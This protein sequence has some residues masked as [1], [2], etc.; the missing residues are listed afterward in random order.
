MRLIKLHLHPF[1]GTVNKI[2]EFGAG[3][4]V[5]YGPNE[6]GKSTI[7]K[8]LLLAL[9]TST[10]LTKPEYKNWVSNFIPI[11]GDT[12]NIDLIFEV[13]GVDYELK[14]SWGINNISTLS[15]IGKAGIHDAEKVQTELMKLLKLNRAALRDVIFTTQAKIASTIEGI[16]KDKDAEVANSLDQILRSA[17][18]NTGGINPEKVKQQL[19]ADFEKL[20]NNWVLD[21]DMPVVKKDN[22]G[23][24]ENKWSN[25][26][27]EI[28]ELAYTIYDKEKALNERLMYDEIYTS[29]ANA[30]NEMNA[31][32]GED[33]S[34]IESNAELVG[35]LVKRKEIN[36]AIESAV[37][38]KQA[39]KDVQ[40][41]WS[42]I[43]ANLPLISNSFTIENEVLGKL[44]VEQTNARLALDFTIKVARFEKII[45]LKNK[46]EKTQA[47]FN[48]AKVFTDKD[49]SIVKSI[50]E[51]LTKARN[52]LAGLEAAQ[53]FI[54]YIQP[55]SNIEADIQHGTSIAEKKSLVSGKSITYEVSKGFVYS[56]SEVTIEVK[57]M[58]DQIS[59]LSKRIAEL[60]NQLQV[61]L[62]KYGVTS[63]ESLLFINEQYNTA[64]TLFNIA[65]SNYDNALVGTNFETLEQE[66]N[67]IKNLPK[68]RSVDEL[69]ILINDLVG[70]IAMLKLNIDNATLK[71]EEYKR[72]YFSLD[73]LDEL[74]LE[75]IQEEKLANEALANLPII[76]E[77]F[78]IDAFRI[79]YGTTL[80][81]LKENEEKL[82][83]LEL[84]RAN[85]DGGQ[86]D[87]LASELQDEIDLLKR[88]KEQKVEEA[89]AIE[90]VLNKLV[91]ILDR[92]A[93]NPYQHY[94]Q[95]LRQYLTTLSGGKYKVVTNEKATPSV[96]KNA[97]SNLELPVEIL[98]QGTSGLL[99]LS[100]R[101]A[102]ADYYLDG[103]N[104]FLV[105][106]DP[107]V[108][109]DEQRQVLTAKC[110][111]R[112]AEKKQVLIFTC[113]K[114][115]ANELGGSLITLN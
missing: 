70:K 104:G 92:T 37:K 107:M 15:E 53:K 99:G 14:K 28:L 16:V 109:F 94:E 87:T 48:T 26:V 67:K 6:A 59:V 2:Y 54:V 82:K 93:I 103:H 34:F 30:I 69:E 42:S 4:N 39:L 8:A 88:Q 12:I 74:R 24:Y 62:T 11:G 60:E 1:A 33:K 96:I 97:T 58:T 22:K 36:L 95:N 50:E 81:R 41:D 80:S 5:V 114:S 44:R 18:L 49:L 105:F 75:A 47:T 63:F 98:S 20:T 7:V 84:I 100:L 46:L 106:D 56:T 52:A 25:G 57:S 110:L 43:N 89:K 115:H 76:A 101:L 68:T 72:I 83:Q 102:M 45:E 21:S 91:E 112:Y 32:V 10:D 79:Q 85:L 29:N 23:S 73:K 35:S 3:L 61:E 9:L 38:K 78:N 65:K 66:V 113:H 27:G 77:G 13:E 51:S 108:D 71:Q 86:P 17:L 55:K 31:I 64:L 19:A 90:K 40:S 111:N